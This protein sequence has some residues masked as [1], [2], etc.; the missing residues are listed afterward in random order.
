MLQIERGIGV[1]LMNIIPPKPGKTKYVRALTKLGLYVFP[2][3]HNKKEPLHDGWQKEATNDPAKY[4]GNS[5][6]NI[7]V[8]CGEG[9]LVVDIDIK[10]KHDGEVNWKALGI[11]ESAFQVKTPSGGR[12]IYY[13]LPKGVRL[14]N[15]ASK[16]ALGVDIRCDGGLVV[17]P[18]SVIDGKMYEFIKKDQK[19]GPA[20]QKLIDLC[21]KKDERSPKFNVPVGKLDTEENCERAKVY[22]ANGAPESVEGSGGDNTAFSVAAR[23]RDMGIS[24]EEC[25]DLM[26]ADWNERCSPPWSGEE[27]KEPVGNA[28]KYASNRIGADTPEVQFEDEPDS[29]PLDTKSLILNPASPLPSAEYFVDHNYTLKGTRTLHSKNGDF[30]K[31]NRTNYRE[32]NTD[33]IRTELYWFLSSA[34]K[35]IKVKGG[36]TIQVPFNPDQANVNKILDALKAVVHLSSDV[37]AP[38][39][40]NSRT[41][42]P[43]DELIVCQNGLLHLPT[44]DLF[45]LDPTYFSLNAINYNF[46]A[47]APQAENWLKFLFSIWG[48]DLEA[49]SCF[50]EIAGYLVSGSTSLQKIPLILGPRRSGKGTCGRV[51]TELLGSINVCSPTMASF[52][53]NFGLQPLIGKTL[54]LLSDARLSSKADQKAITETLLRVSG[55]DAVNVSRKNKTDWY[56]SLATRFLILTNELPKLTDTSGALASRFIILIMRAS[57]LGKEDRDLTSR[58]LKELPGILNWALDGWQRLDKRGHFNVPQSSKDASAQLEDL[59]SPVTAFVRDRC[60]IDQSKSV[61]IDLLFKG[62][63][64][65]CNDEGRHYSGTKAAFKRD[66]CSACSQI[67]EVRPRD[68]GGSRPRLYEGIGLLTGFEGEDKIL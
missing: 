63:R 59:S 1:F 56:G 9:L 22:L 40:L 16:I 52:A 13:S 12:H 14:S 42:P 57:F 20:S 4:K 31:W 66:V 64:D 41:H 32:E 38:C 48:D 55:E 36:G 58:L 29:G 61:E 11:K 8:R 26:L 33:T 21:K 43:A 51:L 35:E 3:K 23:V 54:A 60:I 7:G 5:K 15:S 37:I 18:G 28:Y 50:Q 65:W 49:I 30:Y 46:D 53:N 34:K 67:K 10:G 17:G 68:L 25:L 45:P 19:I 2:V 39:W 47:N 44:R 62:W 27:L 24:E 6:H